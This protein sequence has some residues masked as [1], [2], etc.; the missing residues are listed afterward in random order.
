VAAL[1]TSTSIASSFSTNEVAF[2]GSPTFP[3]RSTASAPC[4]RISAAVSS[5]AES[6]RR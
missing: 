3:R 4:S 6:L 1:E 2:S 5:A